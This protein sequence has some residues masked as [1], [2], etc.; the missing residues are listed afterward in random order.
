MRLAGVSVRH[1]DAD[2][3][4]VVEPGHLVRVR[5]RARV[6]VGVAVGVGVGVGDGVTVRVRVGAR[7]DEGS[8]VRRSARERLVVRVVLGVHVELDAGP[9][10][11]GD[12]RDLRYRVGGWGHIYS[13][14]VMARVRVRDRG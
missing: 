13:S 7:L 8:H 4:A 12:R 9:R 3:A 10:P 6:R 14:V 1:A 11:E 2:R 5:V